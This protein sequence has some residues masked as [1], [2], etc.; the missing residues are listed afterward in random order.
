MKILIATGNKH[1]FAELKKIL[2][3]R[4]KYLSLSDFPAAR[5]PEETGQTLTENALIKARV[6]LKISGLPTLADDTGLFVDALNGAPGVFSARYAG[7]NADYKANNSKLLN[8]LKDAPSSKRSAHF[9][10]VA[11]LALPNGQEYAQEGDSEGF[12]AREP[13][14]ENGFGYDPIFIVK[15]IGKTFAEMDEE[16]KNSLS[17]RNRAFFKIISFL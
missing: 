10:T 14:G 17:H 1:K 9:R 12:I 16:T 6:G 5:E 11:I 2:P 7:E 3:T 8:A 4:H 13:R 15:D